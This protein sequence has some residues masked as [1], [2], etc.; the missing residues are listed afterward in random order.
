[1]H[2][3]KYLAFTG[4]NVQLYGCGVMRTKSY[5]MIPPAVYIPRML[6]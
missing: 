1:M 2:M 6:I 3:Y 4:P 5:K